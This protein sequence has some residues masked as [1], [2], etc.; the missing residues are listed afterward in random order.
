MNVCR[1]IACVV[2]IGAI[3]CSSVA[4]QSTTE[5][6]PFAEAEA[7]LVDHAAPSVP[8]LAK[9]AR[10]GGTVK[11]EVTVSPNG[12]VTSVKV[13]SGHPMLVQAAVESVRKW[14][15]K[16]FL[17]NGKSIQVTAEID[18]TFPGGMSDEESAIR[19]QLFPAEDECRKLIR[20]RDYATAETE[21]QHAVELSDKLP[22]D[23]VLERSDALELLANAIFLQHRFLEAIPLYE[24][25]LKLDRG[26][27][28]ANDADL[29]SDYWNLGRAYAMTGDLNR[30]DGLYRTAVSTFEAAI[31]DLPVMKDNYTQR[32][33]RA[34]TEYAQ[35]KDAE[36]QGGEAS[37]L[38]QKA[39][40][41]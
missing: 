2:C 25:G 32:L 16:P 40:G 13:L 26:Y 31:I 28:K 22:K 37:A 15:F 23:V 6:I 8:P 14:K 3:V 39:A 9:A 38:R 36:G 33:K 30:A 12:D 21:C 17:K 20:N 7:H 41:L 27:R 1:R 10:I 4:A 11:L 35:L 18:V 29:A 34:L 5:K 19:N 24:Q